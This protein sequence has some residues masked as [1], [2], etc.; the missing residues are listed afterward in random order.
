[1]L[2]ETI[3]RLLD[4]YLPERY[5]EFTPEAQADVEQSYGCKRLTM[6]MIDDIAARHRCEE[7]STNI[8]GDAIDNGGAACETEYNF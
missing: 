3:E 2:P 5:T 4:S 8:V 1:M 7:D 6:T